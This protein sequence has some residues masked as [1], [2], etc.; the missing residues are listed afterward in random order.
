M[1]RADRR[2]LNQRTP[3]SLAIYSHALRESPHRDAAE[4]EPHRLC[5]FLDSQPWATPPNA[6]PCQ[7]SRHRCAMHAIPLSKLVD[8]RTVEV[9]VYE[10]VDL[11][12]DEKG[13][14]IL[15]PPNHGAPRVL[16]RG[17]FRALRHPVDAPLPACDQGL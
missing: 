9:V 5:R 8:R 3:H 2:R 10:L 17:G 1:S 6:A 15:N 12:G 7:M 11:R 13:L 14:K 4:M 16:Q